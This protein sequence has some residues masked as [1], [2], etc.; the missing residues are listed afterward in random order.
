MNDPERE[1]EA[2]QRV[3]AAQQPDEKRRRGM[4]AALE[5]YYTA[6]GLQRT[7]RRHGG[8]D[9]ESPAVDPIAPIRPTD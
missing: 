9:G 2:W 7:G 6:I 8:G 5:R 1:Q 3:A 4:A